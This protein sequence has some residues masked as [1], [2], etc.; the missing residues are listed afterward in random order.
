[1][2]LALWRGPFCHGLSSPLLDAQRDRLAESRISMIEE[3]VELDL[4]LGQHGDVV[5]EL[6]GLVA[7]HPLRERLHGLLMLALYRS[8]RQADAL[9]AFRE[10]RRLLQDELGVEPAAPLQRLHQQILS[11]DPELDQTR[12]KITV[13][14]GDG[15]AYRRPVPAQLP[16]SIPDFTDREAELSRLNALLPSEPHAAA[17]PVVIAAITGTAGVG[18]SALAVYWS[19]QAR[20]R[21][22]DGQLYV[23]LRGF[24]PA[25]SAMEPGDAIRSF[26]DAF[27]VPPDRI[28][29]DLEAQGALYRS[30]LAP[31]RVLI[32]LD[33][34]RDGPACAAA[35]ARVAG[36]PGG[37]DQPQPADRPGRRGWCPTRCP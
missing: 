6:R 26:L 31:L 14:G 3:R 23:N 30:M 2:A 21:F 12:T 27:A 19:H 33:N 29:V 11:A 17:G 1:M 35:A 37:G 18:K 34:V 20:E 16:H 4:A 13:S 32:V 10:A 9:A 8:G 5:A 7:E 25:G 36:L 24:D 15:G 22:P 28:P